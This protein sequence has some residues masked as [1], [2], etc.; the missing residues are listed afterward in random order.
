[1]TFTI[2]QLI[3]LGVLLVTTSVIIGRLTKKSTGEGVFSKIFANN[4]E[5][6]TTAGLFGTTAI[7]LFMLLSFHDDL[8][9]DPGS[10]G[11]IFLAA[12]NLMQTIVL[13][14]ARHN[15]NNGGQS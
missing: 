14:K 6:D 13:G 3:I 11:M 4:H 1:M 15:G 5:F 9:Q 7:V 2:T 12:F 8:A 10:L